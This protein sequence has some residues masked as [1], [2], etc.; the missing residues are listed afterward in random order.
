MEKLPCVLGLLILSG[1]SLMVDSAAQVLGGPVKSEVVKDCAS[2][3]KDCIPGS[4]SLVV[5]YV[6]DVAGRPVTDMTVAAVISSK[7]PGGSASPVSGRTDHD[8]MAAV[9]VKPG[10]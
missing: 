10:V 9:S 6:Y 8:G 3:T 2:D 5:V 7:G 1:P 4:T